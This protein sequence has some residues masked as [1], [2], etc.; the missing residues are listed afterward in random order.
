MSTYA[1]N[2]VCHLVERDSA[3]RE[4]MRRDV[5]AALAGFKLEAEELQALKAGDVVTLFRRGAH[6]FLL[7][8]L[9]RYRLVGLDRESYRQRITSLADD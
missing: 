3:F 2:K 8:N 7:Q 5:D 4:R 6:P 1:V 9:G